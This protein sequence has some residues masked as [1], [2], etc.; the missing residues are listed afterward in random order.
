VLVPLL[1]E[2]TRCA[3]RAEQDELMLVAETGDPAL[4]CEAGPALLVVTG[5]DPYAL[6]A[7]AARAV[8]AQVGLGRL[9][10]DKLLPDH[11]DGLG[12]CTWDAFYKDVT[13]D[14]V[15]QGLHSL[16]QAGAA[17]RWMILDDG[18]QSWTRC[19]GGRTG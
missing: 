9:R 15:L 5:A 12:W 7:A 18:W 4:A 10:A 1:G 8:S 13:P 3:L 14:K 6:Q 11:L 17:P 2:R 19:P 16:A